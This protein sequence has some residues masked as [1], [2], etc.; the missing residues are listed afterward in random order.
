MKKGSTLY[1]LLSRFSLIILL[2]TFYFLFSNRVS[3]AVIIVS[4]PTIS[5]RAENVII[6]LNT[7]KQNINAVEAHF[8]FKPA[9][10]SV[11]EVSDGGSIINL[12]IKRPSFSN[13]N[14]T[15]DLAGLVPGGYEGAVGKLITVKII[16]LKAG[17]ASGFRLVSA[18]VLL[19]NGQGT[20]AKVSFSQNEFV[21]NLLSST[22]SPPIA[23]TQPPDPFLPQIGRDSL[24]F[25]G[26]YFLVFSAT[27]QSSGI[28]HYEVAETR[29]E[30]QNNLPWQTTESPAV[31]KDQ[32]LSS[33][34]Y[35]KAVDNVGNYRI[36]AIPPK[37]PVPKLPTAVRTIIGIIVVLSVL[38]LSLKTF[39]FRWKKKIY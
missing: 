21:L 30:S 14:G 7:E 1:F 36:V 33:Y 15:L 32:S 4:P 16:P 19:N 34:I 6:R 11:E 18:D 25:N 35:I 37:L 31:L 38:L 9:E 39:F 24:M 22:S 3:A 8:S 12:W 13:E 17:P 10:F 20:P 28:N 2:S 29:S 27:D 26:R 5:Q 23:D